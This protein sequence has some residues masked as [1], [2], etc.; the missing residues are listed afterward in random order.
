MPTPNSIV[1]R[2]VYRG[3]TDRTGSRIV[4]TNL[5]SGKRVTLPVDN[6]F[7]AES[8]HEYAAIACVDKTAP[9]YA[10]RPVAVCETDS[11]PRVIYWT[12]TVSK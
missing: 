12:F 5:Q 9:R 2:T 3:P 4:A 1:V 11:Q 7:S 6:A 10:S 8:N